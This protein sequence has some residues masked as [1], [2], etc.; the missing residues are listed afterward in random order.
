MPH[1]TG[2]PLD[3]TTQ[4]TFPKAIGLTEIAGGKNLTLQDRRLFDTLLAVAYERI[5]RDEEHSVRLADLRRL[6]VRETA[7]HEHKGNERIKAS[8]KRLKSLVIEFNI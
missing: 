7:E 2:R 6:A 3:L 4:P 8:I 1:A 5:E